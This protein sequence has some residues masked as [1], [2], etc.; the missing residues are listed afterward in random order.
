MTTFTSCG[1]VADALAF[2]LT[3]EHTYLAALT[4]WPARTP[5]Q[6]DLLTDLEDATVCQVPLP[7]QPAEVTLLRRAVAHALD[8]VRAGEQLAGLP[9]LLEALQEPCLT[10]A[11]DRLG[12]VSA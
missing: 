11:L 3:T 9:D 2:P 7:L 4:L 12:S 8:R 1:S 10:R 6:A 5:E